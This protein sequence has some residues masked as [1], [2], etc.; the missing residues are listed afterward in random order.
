MKKEEQWFG[1]PSW[2]F[3][4]RKKKNETSRGWYF[5]CRGRG[6]VEGSRRTREVTD[7]AWSRLSK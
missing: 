1:E 7:V 6:G 3:F 5:Y 4:L 2:E